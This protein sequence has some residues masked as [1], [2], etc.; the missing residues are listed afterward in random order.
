MNFGV[1]NFYAGFSITPVI[2]NGRP[3][4]LYEC[5]EVVPVTLEL[6]GK[7][8][9]TDQITLLIDDN[10]GKVTERRFSAADSITFEVERSSPGFV[11]FMAEWHHK[12]SSVT[13]L[14]RSVGFSVEEIRAEPEPED[15]YSFWKELFDEASALPE[16]PQMSPLNTEFTAEKNDLYELAVPTLNGKTI[17]G[18]LSI[19]KAPGKYP[20]MVGYPGSGPAAGIRPSF[21][22]PD[23]IS[24]FMEVHTYR[25]IP[26][27]SREEIIARAGWYNPFFY[28]VQGIESRESFFYHDIL[29]GIHRALDFIEELPQYDGRNIGFFGSSQ[30]GWLSTMMAAFH[31]EVSAMFLNVPAFT[32]WNGFKSVRVNVAQHSDDP[33]YEK[34]ARETLRYYSSVHAARYTNATVA[35]TVGRIDPICPPASVYALYNRFPGKKVIYHEM[36]MRHECRDSWSEG[37]K[38][39]HD[40]LTGQ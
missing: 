16:S 38:A 17:Y 22:Y 19:P 39:L 14:E 37:V 10:E 35:M 32:Q 7:K 15:F 31:P 27:E 26:H 30:G 23:A 9:E 21:I 13:K 8:E 20:I 6:K 12:E 1:R 33:E 24:L 34:R 25:S 2:G 11:N 3:C 28:A 40:H 4:D 29:P 18:Y 36:D 5:G